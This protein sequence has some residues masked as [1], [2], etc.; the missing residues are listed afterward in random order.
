MNSLGARAF[1]KLGR[2]DDAYQL[3]SL[4]VAP[5]AQCLK[6]STLV[7]CH[8][9]LGQVTAKRG[10]TGEADGHFAKALEEARLSRLPMLEV[11]ALRDWKKY[12]LEPGGR[13]CSAVE[14]A[15]DEACAKMKKSRDRVASVLS[16]A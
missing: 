11:L 13:D 14:L 12:V 5:E 7:T 3:A 1:L 9:I 16:S 10:Q 15:I 6:K 4:T 2:D 8:S